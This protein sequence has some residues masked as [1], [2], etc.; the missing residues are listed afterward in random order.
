MERDGLSMGKG[1]DN[2]D[3]TAGSGEWTNVIY[4]QILLINEVKFP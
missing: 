4:L 3:G 1:E 2:V